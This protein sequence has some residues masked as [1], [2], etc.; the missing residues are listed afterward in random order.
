MLQTRPFRIAALIVSAILAMHSSARAFSGD[1]PDW[2]PEADTSR[3]RAAALISEQ[4]RQPRYDDFL[5]L[6]FANLSSPPTTLGAPM[7]Y[8]VFFGATIFYEPP[9]TIAQIAGFSGIPVHPDRDLYIFRC[10]PP[11]RSNADPALALWPNLISSMLDDYDEH[12]PQPNTPD[13][14]LQR[15]AQSFD[16]TSSMVLTETLDNALNVGKQFFERYPRRGPQRF[17]AKQMQDQMS[18]R[19]GAFTAFTG[20]GYAAEGTAASPSFDSE[21]TMRSMVIPD[22]VL[23]N[24]TLAEA[25]CHCIKVP[26]TV[27]NRDRRKLDPDLIVRRDNYGKCVTVTRTGAAAAE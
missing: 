15:I 19:F 18:L 17:S 26:M 6:I 11:R 24:V 5:R 4:T 27:P 25:G 2:G 21:Q 9:I 8:R 10:I 14:A 23:R 16:D 12:P 13:E 20:L 22:F 7:A 3:S 1:S